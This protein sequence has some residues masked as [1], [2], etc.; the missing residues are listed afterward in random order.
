MLSRAD[1][2]PALDLDALVEALADAFAALSAGRASMPPRTGVDVPGDGRP[3][4]GAHR[5]RARPSAS[6]SSR[7][8]RPRSRP[9]GG[10]RRLRRRHRHAGRADGRR[11]DHRGAHRRRLAARHAA[12]RPRG[13]RRA[14]G[15]RHRRPGRGARERPAARARVG[16]GAV[17]GAAPGARWPRA[18]GTLRVVEAAVRGADVVCVA[19]PA[20]EPVAA[21][22]VARARRARQLRRLHDAGPRA[23]R[24]DG[25]RRACRGRVARVRARAAARGQQ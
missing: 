20:T 16:R 14:R 25:P 10:D 11:R 3:A 1:V 19:T 2:E 4:M 5:P 17:A 13:R 22:R 7:S 8:S 9:P 21:P 24:G 23:R 15:G 6:S 18:S 12:A